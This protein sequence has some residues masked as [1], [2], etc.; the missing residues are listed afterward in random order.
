MDHP[1]RILVLTLRVPYPPHDGGALAAHQTLQQLQA[2]GHHVTLAALNTSKHPA[3]PADVAHLVQAAHATA[4]DTAL[5]PLPALANLVA[6]RLPYN[7]ARFDVPAHHQLLRGL[8]HDLKPHLVHLEGVHLATYLPTLQRA[9]RAPAVLRAHNVEHTLWARLAAAE[10][11]A[12]KRAYYRLLAR[13][14]RRFE[15]GALPHMAGLAAIAPQDAEA[16]RNL[17][18][19]GPMAVIPAG[20]ELPPLPPQAQPRSTD[21]CFL[22]SLEW[23]PNQQGLR[24]FI[25]E[26]WPRVLAQRPGARFHVAG[27]NPPTHWPLWQAPGVVLHGA[28]PSAADFWQAHGPAAIPLLAGSG[29]RLKL[30]EALAQG[31]AVVSTRQGA[32]GVAVQDGTHLLLADEPAAFAQALLRLMDDDALRQRLQTNGR[33]LV[34]QHYALP[35]LRQ[36]LQQLYQQVLQG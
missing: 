4:V 7:V 26:V 3:N 6:S 16:F 28:V 34:A 9:H 18:Y 21:P 30:V 20:V 31:K 32:E 25:E 13:R 12:P 22:G 1:L 33:A 10:T 17:G 23:F 36:D 29:M 27:R 14:M 2:L 19:H 8:A 15:L 35:K 24:W 5:R 11:N